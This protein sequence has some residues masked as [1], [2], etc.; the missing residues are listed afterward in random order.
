MSSI[1]DGFRQDPAVNGAFRWHRHCSDELCQRLLKGILPVHGH[2]NI[3]S[4]AMVVAVIA[5]L[6]ATTNAEAQYRRGRVIVAPRVIVGGPIFYDPWFDP[7]YG[8]YEFQY[9]Y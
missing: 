8:A 2:K 9:P 5:V 3:T 7:F 6:G 4:S 1:D